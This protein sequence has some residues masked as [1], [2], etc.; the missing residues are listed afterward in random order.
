MLTRIKDFAKANAK[1]LAIGAVA[2]L[3]IGLMF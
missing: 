1:A 3:V 2:G